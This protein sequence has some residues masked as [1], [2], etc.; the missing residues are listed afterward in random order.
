MSSIYLISQM[1]TMEK[2]LGEGNT[3]PPRAVQAIRWCMTLKKSDGETENLITM[4][5][6]ICKNYI[7]QEELGET[8]Y[9]HYQC[10]LSLKRKMRM[11]E[12][13]KLFPTAHFEKCKG[14]ESENIKYCS[15]SETRSAGPFFSE[16]FR[17]KEELTF[18]FELKDWELL[19]LDIV[20]KPADDR[21]I[22]WLYDTI[23]GCG[24]TTF[25]KYLVTLYGAG[26]ISG[27]SNDIKYY[28][29]ENDKR[30]YIFDFTR[31]ME[32]YVSYQ[33]IEE[34][35]NGIYFSGKYE[36][37]SIVRSCPHIIV[38]ANFEPDL[39]KLSKDRWR[40]QEVK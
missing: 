30:I 17:P 7:F 34:I 38:F 5:K 6:D 1:E 20:T 35:K 3:K 14:S 9:E 37:K 10:Y 16:A 33:S 11:T 21:T 24:K 18:N 25:S 39:D 13:K 15:K 29:A 19:I 8:G 40:V 36:S 23:G 31:S 28:C 26:Y 27:K 22:W 2:S 12:L 4:F 32:T